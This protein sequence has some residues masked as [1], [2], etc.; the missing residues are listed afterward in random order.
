MNVK[1][2]WYYNSDLLN[3]FDSNGREITI[4]D[5]PI[6]IVTNNNA[7]LELDY[8]NNKGFSINSIY[9]LQATIGELTSYFSIP[10]RAN[11]NCLY[12][13]GATEVVYQTNGDPIY[14][15]QPYALYQYALQAS[16]I[17]ADTV[18]DIECRIV[19]DDRYKGAYEQ[20]TYEENIEA[21]QEARVD[22]SEYIYNN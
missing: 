6:D 15:K 2:A 17:K 1:W 7:V 14:S 4:S 22:V 3:T 8:S 19:F 9:I 18:D 5:F 21:S 11:S 20:I 16:E 10:V 13:D 12:I